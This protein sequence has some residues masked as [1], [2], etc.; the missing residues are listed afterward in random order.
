MNGAMEGNQADMSAAIA[1]TKNL[2]QKLKMA[3]YQ[4]PLRAPKRADIRAN[5]RSGPLNRLIDDY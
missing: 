4:A 3:D 2:L 1:N 5:V